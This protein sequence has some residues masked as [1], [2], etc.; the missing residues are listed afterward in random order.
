MQKLSICLAGGL[1]AILTG[2]GDTPAPGPAAKKEIEK[3]APV[4]GQTAIFRMYGL[5]RTWAPDAQ[6]LEMQNIHLS[7]TKDSAPGTAAA[8][9]AVFVSAEKAKSRSYTYS[10]VQG[11]DNLHKGA[12]AGPE[13]AI[14]GAQGVR[15]PF[16]M[17]A[18]KIDSDA[19]YKTA[20]ETASTKA[21]DYDKKNPGK[22]ITILLEKTN[23]HPDAAWRIVW[24]ASVGTSDFSVVIDAS[25]GAFLETI[26]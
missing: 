24:G 3:P 23:K 15:T 6:V 4:T 16:L 19:A 20:M 10:I 17:A 12:F 26:R 11:E 18:V 14:A 1:L 2:C 9:E 7:E 21:A 8:W 25:T 13:D 22:P 5:A